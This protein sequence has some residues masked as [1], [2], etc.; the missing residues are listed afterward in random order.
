MVSRA[1]APALDARLVVRRGAFTLDLA[2]AIAPGETVALLG[3]NGAG[4]TTAV[5]CLA[6]LLPLAEGHIRLGSRPLDDPARRV[7]VPPEKRRTG[8]VFQ[9]YLLFPHMTAS[10]NVAFGLR[11]AGYPRREARRLA[12]EWL[13]R[14]GLEGLADSPAGRLSGGQAQQVALART[15]AAAPDLLLL[16]E[17]LAALDVT[18]RARL[19]RALAAHLAEHPGPRLLIT[20]RPTGAF[21][22]AD[23]IV[24]LEEGRATQEGTPDEI[25]RHPRTAYA[26]DLAGVNLLAGTAAGGV[27][28]VEGGLTLRPGA[29]VAD[30]AVLVTV[31]P[32][33]VNLFPA[34][35][36][37][38]GT[39][40]TWEAEVDAVE[41]LG[42]RTRIVL[43][44]PLP[45][46]AET[47]AAA[48]AALRLRPGSR[49]R[50]AVDPA[51]ITAQPA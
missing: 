18:T 37:A 43:R 12:V 16:D 32:R 24:V 47:A 48:A 6:G 33:S 42:E 28:T 36:P 46:V 25:R 49:V 40:T 9:D 8:V 14:F 23:R 5:S 15:L 51:E 7:F 22:L 10:E 31:H 13:G 30:G 34:G 1:A 29:P 41:A 17:P 2:L 19:R 50:V 20:H 44:P 26:A 11:G 38:P 3:P 27:V 21:L 39:G 45:L 35:P 4:K